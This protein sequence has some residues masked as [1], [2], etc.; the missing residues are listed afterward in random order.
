MKKVFALTIVIYLFLSVAI[1]FCKEDFNIDEIFSYGLANSENGFAID[2]EWNQEYKDPE[3]VFLN[4]LTVSEGHRFDYRNVWAN[5]AI[6]VHPPLYYALLH[7]LCSFF[8]GKFSIWFAAAINIVFSILTAYIVYK[9]FNEIFLIENKLILF[10]ALTGLAGCELHLIT[11]LRMYIMLIFECTL[12]AYLLLKYIKAK[13]RKRDYAAMG[14]LTVL[15]ADRKS[16][17]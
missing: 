1:L 2:Y 15:G 17:V 9:I 4:Y 13:F 5:Q 3:S 16:V 11:F 10:F 8:P 7:T 12:A 14:I 6:D